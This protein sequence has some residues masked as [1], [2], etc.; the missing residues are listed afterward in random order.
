[1]R[2]SSGT[3]YSSNKFLLQ[4]S[5]SDD[6][7]PLRVRDVVLLVIPSITYFATMLLAGLGMLYIPASICFMVQVRS[8]LIMGAPSSMMDAVFIFW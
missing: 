8:V 5:Q 1:M 2:S 4:V 7:S 3:D 6:F